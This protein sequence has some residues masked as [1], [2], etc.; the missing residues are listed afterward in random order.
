MTRL[1][2]LPL[3]QRD[4]NRTVSKRVVSVDQ[5]DKNTSILEYYKLH[6]NF[7]LCTFCWIKLK[8]YR[9]LGE[10]SHLNKCPCTD[11]QGSN[12]IK[13][14]YVHVRYTCLHAFTSQESTHAC[15]KINV[16]V[17]IVFTSMGA[18][19]EDYRIRR[20]F[21]QFH[22]L[23]SLTKIFV[24]I[25]VLVG[26]TFFFNWIFLKYKVAGLGE[27]FMLELHVWQLPPLPTALILRLRV[28]IN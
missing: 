16:V 26:K 8:C 5:R 22:H 19:S 18:H 9:V 10:C 4:I 25:F 28:I 2:T 24:L 17:S 3:A 12:F 13:K 27:I 15:A 20:N 21:R 11:F 6:Y 7:M 14:I 23:L 1:I